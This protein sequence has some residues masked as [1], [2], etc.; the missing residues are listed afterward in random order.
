MQTS[1]RS[2][3][4]PETINLLLTVGTDNLLAG[5]KDHD[6]SVWQDLSWTP[7]LLGQTVCYVCSLA[8]TLVDKHVVLRHNTIFISEQIKTSAPACV[9]RSC[10]GH[11]CVWGYARF[12]QT[13]K[14]LCWRCKPLTDTQLLRMSA[15]PPCFHEKKAES[16]TV[17]IT[18]SSVSC[19]SAR[20][21][22]LTQQL[23]GLPTAQWALK[24]F[25]G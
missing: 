1:F 21:V 12:S 14:P 18:L 11:V 17:I 4:R 6:Q 9:C 10:C 16:L 15:C 19:F 7:E 22:K 20:S 3:K 5:K 8:E 13:V 24:Q 23:E 25:G 2:C